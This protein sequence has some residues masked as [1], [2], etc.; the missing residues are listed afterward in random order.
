MPQKTDT[1]VELRRAEKR[2]ASTRWRVKNF[3]KGTPKRTRDHVRGLL[4]EQEAQVADLRVR[5]LREKLHD[6]QASRA[7]ERRRETT[8]A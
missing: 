7:P 1:A 4:E 3:A 5:A 6:M 2:A 8:A